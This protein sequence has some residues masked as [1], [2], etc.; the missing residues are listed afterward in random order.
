MLKSLNHHHCPLVNKVHHRHFLQNKCFK[1]ICKYPEKIKNKPLVTGKLNLVSSVLGSPKIN[2]LL[3][4]CFTVL[5]TIFIMS[6][7]FE[8]EDCL[9][10]FFESTFRVCKLKLYKIYSTI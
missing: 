6:A 10:I 3:T 1:I 5:G 9:G 8:A 4:G 7:I 2:L